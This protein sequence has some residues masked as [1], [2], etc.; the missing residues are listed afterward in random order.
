MT[1]T[2]AIDSLAATLSLQDAVEIAYRDDLDWIADNLRRHTNVLI[3]CDKQIVLYLYVAL[4]ERLRGDASAMRLQLIGA[5][6]PDERSLIESIVQQM[7]QAIFS[8]ECESCLVIPHLDVVAASNHANLTDRAREVVAMIYENPDLRLLAF[9][10]PSFELPPAIVAAFQAR[11]TLLGIPRHILPALITQK[12]A[13]KFGVDAFSPFALYPYVSGVNAVRFRQIM[14]QITHRLDYDPLR[15]DYLAAI[16]QD[17]RTMTMAADMAMVNVDLDRDIAGYAHVKTRI[18]E[19]ILDLLRYKSS[20]TEAREIQR[21]EE[22]I[23]KGM[24]FVGPPGT[25]KTFFAKAIATALD[26]SITIVSG[27][28]LKSK[29][30]GESEENLRRVF[31]QARKSAPAII[32]FDELDSFAT[33]R[34]TYAGSGVEHSMVNQ[35]LTEMDGFRKDELLFIVGTTN[36]PDALDPALLRPGR[37]ELVIEIPYPNEEDRRAII[38]LYR[39]RFDLNLPPE[40]CRFLVHRSAAYVDPDKGTRYSGDHLYA[41]CRALKRIAIRRFADNP[42]GPAPEAIPLTQDDCERALDL[43]P[44]RAPY[45]PPPLSEHESFTVACHECG[46]ALLAMLCPHAPK[47]ERV[48][49]A[50]DTA[51]WAPQALGFVLRKVSSRRVTTEAELLDEICV[52]LGG[53][54]AEALLLPDLSVGAATDLQQAAEI[55]RA[56]CADLAMG[57][58]PDLQVYPPRAQRPHSALERTHAAASQILSEQY[59]R[60]QDILGQHRDSLEAMSQQLL[61]QKSLSAEELACHLHTVEKAAATTP[62]SPSS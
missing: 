24:L 59:Q 3:E 57:P 37:F 51:S 56:M 62:A 41:I 45:T 53:R 32:V 40:L 14:A 6:Q 21:I 43:Q 50:G 54:A 52:L 13:R 29:W 25:G 42:A 22:I 19:E 8:G 5:P 16:F 47:V 11:R 27:P 46:H 30:V 20:R 9:K 60:A 10:D 23:P 44:Q 26:A 15:P 38:D 35:L 2:V 18:R 55:A 7:R 36:F 31:A 4:R 12:E 1:T 48:S 28:E 34:G 61:E 58:Q 17:I 49:I 39:R 33:A